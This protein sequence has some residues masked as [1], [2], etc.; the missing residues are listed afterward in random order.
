MDEFSSL[1]Y[2]HVYLIFIHTFICTFFYDFISHTKDKTLIIKRIK[3]FMEEKN[4]CCG[5]TSLTV[6]DPN[7]LLI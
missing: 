5:K 7:L 2:I 3:F 6:C 1:Y 4:I